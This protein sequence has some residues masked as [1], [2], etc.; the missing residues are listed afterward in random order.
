MNLE[1]VKAFL[2]KHKKKILINYNSKTSIEELA[3]FYYNG[4]AIDDD[5]INAF[6]EVFLQDVTPIIND[7]AEFNEPN[8]SAYVKSFLDKLK[9]LLYNNDDTEDTQEEVDSNGVSTQESSD[10]K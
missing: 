5:L 4:I 7:I 10:K 1:I 9:D 8:I 6:T 2:Q 3:D